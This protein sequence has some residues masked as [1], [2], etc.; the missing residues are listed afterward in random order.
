MHRITKVYLCAL[1]HKLLILQRWV[2]F[3]IK[4]ISGRLSIGNWRSVLGKQG[5]TVALIRPTFQH[6]PVL[7]HKRST[8][9]EK[10][11]LAFNPVFL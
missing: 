1:K 4:A 10:K 2:L 5:T 6:R 3:L 11:N 7:S 9:N 8:E